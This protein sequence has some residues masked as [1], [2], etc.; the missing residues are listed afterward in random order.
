MKTIKNENVITER[1][2]NEI[3][4]EKF[5]NFMK[6]H[7]VK[8]R[9][10]EIFWCSILFAINKEQSDSDFVKDNWA[11]CKELKEKFGLDDAIIRTWIT[12]FY[13]RQ[14]GLNSIEYGMKHLNHILLTDKEIDTKMR[15]E[16]S[17][18]F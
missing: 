5:K 3:M 18:W 11:D 6:T 8:K 14:A 1:E 7:S 9:H 4:N 12:N 2:Y 17:N 13:K 10:Q 16:H 15:A